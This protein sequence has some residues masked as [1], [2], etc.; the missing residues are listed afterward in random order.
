MPVKHG[1][2]GLRGK[3]A[4]KLTPRQKTAIAH[5]CLRAR[6]SEHARYHRRN[7]GWQ[8]IL[9]FDLF[10]PPE[11]A[12]DAT[13]TCDSL[14]ENFPGSTREEVKDDCPLHQYD[15]RGDTGVWHAR[16]TT[17]P[18]RRLGDW[19]QDEQKDVKR[20][21]MRLLKNVGKGEVSA[22]KGS[23]DPPA[24]IHFYRKATVAEI[25]RARKAMP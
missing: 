3:V 2:K 8:S 6:G 1:P 19:T 11:P 15:N 25:R 14:L 20:V 18:V 21:L 17:F 12:K 7:G 10:P 16:C 22:K 5:P 9:T 24:T 4:G 23:E 13:C